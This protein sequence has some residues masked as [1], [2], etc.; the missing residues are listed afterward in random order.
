M[1]PAST[2]HLSEEALDDVLIGLGTAE[3]HAH[4]EVCAECRSR[5][6]TV[7]GDIALFN[8]ASMAWSESRRP[9]ARV[10]I[11]QAKR[12]PAAFVG[13]A[14]AA[15]AMVMMA[16]GIWHHR[17]ENPANQANTHIAQPAPAADSE[18]QIAQDNQFLQDVNAAIST[19]EASPIDEYKIVESASPHSKAH[20]KTR[21][22]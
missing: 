19:D 15:A 21:I 10:S 2:I 14:T 3:S 6:A 12:L 13:W 5:V 8:A 4:L 1:T 9:Q 17:A 16:F 20:S 7:R 11:S 22:K 18:A